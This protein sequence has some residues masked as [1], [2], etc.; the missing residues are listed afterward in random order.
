MMSSYQ[1]DSTN[2]MDL[3]DSTNSTDSMD[4]IGSS[5]LT[6]SVFKESFHFSAAHFLIFDEK[7][8]ERL[9][10]HNYRAR[11]KLFLTTE[12]NKEDSRNKENKM[13]KEGE[14]RGKKEEKRGK[15]PEP[16]THGYAIDFKILKEIFKAE[17]D[18]LDERVL[19]PALHPDMK[20]HTQENTLEVRFRD[21]FYAFPKKEV[22]LLP[23][24]NTS[25]EGFAKLLAHNTFS[26][27]SS[28]HAFLSALEVEV[29]ENLGQSAT[30]KLFLGPSFDIT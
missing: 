12:E 5:H 8:A 20:F 2:S 3:M 1:K 29:E 6:L 25:S 13:N 23:L 24:K 18:I 30:Y 15:E 22:L 16:W 4:L 21:R 27:M 26:K 17:I 11:L 10:G 28:Y 9:H 19:L 7:R 14:R